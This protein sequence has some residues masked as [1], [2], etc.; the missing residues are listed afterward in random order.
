MITEET[1]ERWM[2]YFES[3]RN[4]KNAREGVE[5]DELRR[6]NQTMQERNE[7]DFSMQEFEDALTW[8]TGGRAPGED[9]V[10]IEFVKEE[11]PQ[12]KKYIF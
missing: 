12:V 3:L 4:V 8:M 7:D 2:E 1:N 11:G 10:V 9:G 6:Q 5:E